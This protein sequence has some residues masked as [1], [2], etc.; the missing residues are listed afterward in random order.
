M[1]KF[2]FLTD[3]TLSTYLYQSTTCKRG[4]VHQV[5]MYG[6]AITQAEWLTGISQIEWS[7]Q[8]QTQMGT[9]RKYQSL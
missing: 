2:G 4:W 7:T 1:G 6:I 8:N 5:S 9:N 3:H